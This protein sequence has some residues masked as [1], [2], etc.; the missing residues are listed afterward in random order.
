MLRDGRW[1]SRTKRDCGCN[2]E[3][4]VIATIE[5][6]LE[7]TSFSHLRLRQI[8]TLRMNGLLAAHCLRSALVRLI[9]RLEGKLSRLRLDE[10]EAGISILRGRGRKKSEIAIRVLPVPRILQCANGV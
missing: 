1:Q 3:F 8:E 4:S 2:R 10:P 7:R 5:F 9:D 6:L